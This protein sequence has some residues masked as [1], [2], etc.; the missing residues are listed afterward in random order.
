MLA[1]LN[2]ILYCWNCLYIDALWVRDEFRKEGYGSAL[3]IEVE[4]IAK[5]KG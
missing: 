4:K 2:S 1:G 3:L 5:E